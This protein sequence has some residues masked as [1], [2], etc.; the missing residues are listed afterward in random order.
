MRSNHLNKNINYK[1]IF[2]T[3][4]Q[5][6]QDYTCTPTVFESSCE[7]SRH[8]ERGNLAGRTAL[9]VRGSAHWRLAVQRH[10]ETLAAAALADQLFGAE[11]YLAGGTA[12]RDPG[13]PRAN[14]HPAAYLYVV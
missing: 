8:S 13:E 4:R 7:G 5:T 9:R 1:T 12:G 3:V 6:S 2:P 14:R 10:Q 11:W